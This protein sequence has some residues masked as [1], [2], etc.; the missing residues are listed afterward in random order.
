MGDLRLT[1]SQS[2]NGP[3][4]FNDLGSLDGM[5]KTEFVPVSRAAVGEW[6]YITRGN[7]GRQS[8]GKE[9][10]VGSDSRWRRARRGRVISAVQLSAR[11]KTIQLH[12]EL[13]RLSVC[14]GP[15]VLGSKAAS[16]HRVTI[17]AAAI[18]T[19]LFCSTLLSPLSARSELH[20]L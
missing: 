12:G 3:A 16:R 17:S 5:V 18:V 8:R 14:D 1:L 10:G 7:A 2:I 15:A 11:I 20:S 19:S 9:S 4:S 6:A 13:T